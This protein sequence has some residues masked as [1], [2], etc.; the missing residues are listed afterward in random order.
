MSE[1][2]QSSHTFNTLALLGV[3]GGKAEKLRGQVRSSYG[4]EGGNSVLSGFGTVFS[5]R[6]Y[7]KASRSFVRERYGENRKII[8]YDSVLKS[9]GVIEERV[10]GS[11]IE[12]WDLSELRVGKA[13]ACL[14]DDP[15]VTF[16][17]SPSF[18]WSAR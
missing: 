16:Q 12:D 4:E 1:K 3:I 8:R 10:D 9:R 13:V 2:P 11:V 6:L 15:P 7:D 5:F 18:A 17:F 14:P